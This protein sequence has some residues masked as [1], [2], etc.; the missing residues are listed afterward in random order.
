MRTVLVGAVESTRVALEALAGRGAPPAAVFTLPRAE[1]RRH[2]DYVDLRPVAARWN[3]PVRD[4]VSVNATEVLDELRA[5]EPTYA[6][7]IGWSQICRRPFLQIPRG[8]AIGFH[9][10][11]L[12]ENRGRAVIPWTILQS[13]TDT[14]STLFWLDEGVDSGDILLQERFPL[15]PDET[16]AT[17]YAKH[18]EALCRMLAAAIPMLQAET[19]PRA[20]QD[21]SQATYCAKRVP[22]DGLID[23]RAP[24]RAVWTLI[25][26]SGDPYPGAFSLYRG[27]YLFVWEADYVGEAPYT[28]LPGQV[29]AIRDGGALVQCGDGRHVLL[30]VVQVDG[31]PR[32]PAA[33]VVRNHARLGIDL[34]ALHWRAHGGAA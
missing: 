2:A 28:G 27:K 6:F 10:T 5:L 15:Q 33:H 7:V 17:L 3:V 22:A 29:Q 19:A 32:L 9:P 20:P 18:L 30:K 8:G 21:H 16:A 12:P 31:G 13:R 14:G 11:P 1:S 26:A 25:R 23:W 24:A 4:V 34:L